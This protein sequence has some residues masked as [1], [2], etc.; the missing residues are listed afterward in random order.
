M[1]CLL[2]ENKKN[3]ALFL[4]KNGVKYIRC[5]DCGLI[6]A[7]KKF[8][9]NNLQKFYD[10]KEYFK[11]Y[12]KNYKFFIEIF[13]KMLEFIEKFKK[14]GKIL[15]IGCG[16]GLFLYVAKKRNW[17]EFG[18]EPSKFAFNF[19]KNNLQLNVINSDELDKFSNGFFNVIVLNHVLEHIGNPFSMLKQ[20]Y[21][22]LEKHGILIIGVPNINGVFPRIQKKNWPS[23][24]PHSHYYQFTPRTLKIL[25]RMNSFKPI[26]F[27]TINRTFSY[28]N[29]LLN[30]FLNKGLNPILEKLKLGEAMLYVFKKT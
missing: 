17:I 25:L 15:D 12:I 3:F 28:K 4:E 11:G 10:N 21:K 24:R 29:K 27:I 9:I 23:L 7:Q 19:A 22:K 30:F 13:N 8:D 26:R 1:K 14:S 2:C 16:I 5:L 18:L 6:F 20:I